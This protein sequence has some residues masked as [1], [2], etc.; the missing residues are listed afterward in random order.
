[1]GTNERTGSRPVPLP[2]YFGASTK[3]DVFF[4]PYTNGGRPIRTQVMLTHHLLSLVQEGEKEVIVAGHRELVDASRMVLLASTSSI[5]SEHD[6][7]GRPMRS[8]LIFIAPQFL[9]DFCARHGLKPKGTAAELLP[10]PQDDFTRLFARSVEVLGPTALN[11]DPALRRTKAEE[12]LLYLHAKHPADFARF[13]AA[14][15]KGRDELPLRS[16]V[17]LHQDNNL[18]VPELAFLCHMSVSTFK[19]RFQEAYGLAPGR[20]LH[21]RRMERAKAMLVRKLR[22]SEIYIELG[23]GSLASFSTEFKKH[24]GVAPSAQP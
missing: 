17:A 13:I 8:L 24:F 3:A 16:V 12:L 6:L 9:L 4:H 20:Y 2:A 15:V 11:G 23:Y 21:V 5:M 18:S 7:R 1:M 22:P 14:A 19:R 10:M